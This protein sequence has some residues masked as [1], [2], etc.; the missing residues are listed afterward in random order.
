MPLVNNKATEKHVAS[1][2]NIGYPVDDAIQQPKK[3]TKMDK[4]LEEKKNY[5]KSQWFQQ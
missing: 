1:P 4:F 3:Q 5:L 2:L